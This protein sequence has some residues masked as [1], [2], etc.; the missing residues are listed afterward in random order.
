MLGSSASR[1]ICASLPAPR[2][3]RTRMSKSRELFHSPSMA[4]EESIHVRTVSWLCIFLPPNPDRVRL[5]GDLA[6]IHTHCPR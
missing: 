1:K 2:I 3:V 4:K 6:V 5:S